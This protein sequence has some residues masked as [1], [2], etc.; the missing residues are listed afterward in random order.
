MTSRITPAHL[1]ER[2]NSVKLFDPFFLQDLKPLLALPDGQSISDE[3]LECHQSSLLTAKLRAWAA[4]ICS[5]IVSSPMG[6]QQ[7]L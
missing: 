3:V 5:N 7:T 4:S 6:F 1:K 2:L